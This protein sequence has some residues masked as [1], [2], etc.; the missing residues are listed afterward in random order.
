MYAR[1]P[2]K[3]GRAVGDA[4]ELTRRRWQEDGW[5]TEEPAMTVSLMTRIDERLNGQQFGSITVETRVV[6]SLGPGSLER[7]TG[8]DF[9]NILHVDFGSFELKK[10]FLAQAKK[11]ASG[12]NLVAHLR[13]DRNLLGQCE[14]MLDITPA[15]FVF[16][17]SQDRFSVFP[18][19]DVYEML[20]SDTLKDEV[21]LYRKGIGAFYAE[22]FRTFIGDHHLAEFARDEKALRE[23]AQR[24]GV[25]KLLYIGMYPVARAAW[26]EHRPR[27]G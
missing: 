9:A 14:K 4:A 12:A 23:F 8:A 13:G 26:R 5:F 16:T 24:Y 15:A 20:R 21:R 18:A 17:Y 11:V 2:A 27:A 1:Y 3:L 10:A 22:F 19:L 7:A 25:D 6:T